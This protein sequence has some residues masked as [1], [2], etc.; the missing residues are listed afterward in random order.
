M[1]HSLAHTRGTQSPT[2]KPFCEK[3]GSHGAINRRERGQWMTVSQGKEAM[4]GKD[5]MQLCK[6]LPSPRE[7]SGRYM[8]NDT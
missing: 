5:P 4:G 2:E 6:T 1:T 8:E 3:L 7:L